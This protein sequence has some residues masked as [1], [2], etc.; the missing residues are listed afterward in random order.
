MDQ[1]LSRVT[2]REWLFAAAGLCCPPLLA[3]EDSLHA[4]WQTLLARHVRWNDEGT[5]TTVDYAGFRTDR[6][7]LD[8]YLDALSAIAR[9]RFERWPK[10]ERDA[11]L[12]N[13]YNAFTVRLILDAPADVRSI[14]DL[15]SLFRSPWKQRFFDLLGERR[16]LDEVEHELLRGAPDYRDPRIHFAVNCASIG[17]PALRQEAYSGELLDAQLEDQT[18]RFLADRARNRALPAQR[19]M[20]I[21]PIFD[22]YREDFE[23]GFAGAESLP[24]FL[25]RYADVFGLDAEQARSLAAG[26]WRIGFT[27]YD[28]ALNG[29]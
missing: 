21:S 28:W 7:L 3:S 15:G 8:R 24:K 16:H 5:A 23:R 1:D 27:E 25:A 26:G 20:E 29:G 18:R 22:W 19:R 9:E 4:D 14:R 11:F 6:A 10:P 17:C 13:A 2:R 12:I